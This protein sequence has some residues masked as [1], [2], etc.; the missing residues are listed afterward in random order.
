MAQHKKFKE[1][2]KFTY[3]YE[4]KILNVAAEN[5]SQKMKV[6]NIKYGKDHI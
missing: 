2:K 1:V 3:D 5:K 4:G 6:F